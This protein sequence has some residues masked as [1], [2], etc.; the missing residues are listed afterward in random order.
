MKS[1]ILCE[2]HDDLWFSA[3]YL[4]KVADWDECEKSERE[5]I[6]STYRIPETNKKQSVIYM[7]HDK[8]SCAI[9]S[10]S[11]KDCFIPAIETI[12]NKFISNFP[13]DPVESIVI[14]RDRDTDDESAVL[15]NYSNVFGNGL[16]LENKISETYSKSVDGETVN[17]KITPVIIPFDD[18]GAIESLLME[19]VRES[20]NEGKII[21]EEACKYIDVL[22]DNPSIGQ[23][24]LRHAKDVIKA[25]YAA[26]IAATNPSH[27]TGLFQ[28]LMLLCPWE[29][30]EC[31][32]RHFDVVLNAVST[33]EDLI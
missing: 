12:I 32:K 14:L 22:K 3:Y 10:V 2:G 8:D 1:I 25:K 18:C 13:S 17:V 6:W 20:G 16:V 31:V 4:N 29:K 24:Y 11:G 21:V 27:S 26:T 9:W 15:S 23:M 7:R 19:S 30:T 5:K 28:D 33:V